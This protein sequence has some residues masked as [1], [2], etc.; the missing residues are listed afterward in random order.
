MTGG[1]K[2]RLREVRA[3]I[4]GNRP[5]KSRSDALY[6]VYV[7]VITAGAYG[8]LRPSSC[9]VLWTRSGWLPMPGPLRG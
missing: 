7:A 8:V 5:D 3:A 6:P 9:S 4:I 2:Q 1:D